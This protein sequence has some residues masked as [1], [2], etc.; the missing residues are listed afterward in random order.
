MV[1]T[2]GACE[3]GIGAV[4]KYLARALDGSR[5]QKIQAHAPW[6]QLQVRRLDAMT[7]QLTDRRGTERVVGDR[8][9]HLRAMA[10]PGQ[11]NRDVGFSTPDTGLETGRLQQQLPARRA[12]AQQ[13]FPETDDVSTHVAAP[14]TRVCR[15]GWRPAGLSSGQRYRPSTNICCCTANSVTVFFDQRC[16]FTAGFIFWGMKVHLVHRESALERSCAL[17]RGSYANS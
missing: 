6:P 5:C 3:S 17:R 10:E 15:S 2:T 7:T 4:V 9:D 16:H 1:S 12:Q 13:Q 8:S 11:R 14:S